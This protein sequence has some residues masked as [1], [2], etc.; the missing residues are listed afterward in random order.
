M[1]LKAPD[2]EAIAK[3]LHIRW[4]LMLLEALPMTIA[5]ALILW[6][7]RIR[8][9]EAVNDGAQLIEDYGDDWPTA[10]QFYEDRVADYAFAS[11]INRQ[12]NNE[13]AALLS[14]SSWC[15]AGGIVY[16]L[17][18]VLFAIGRAQWHN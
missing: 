11:S 12:L 4:G 2:A 6:A 8:N 14:W 5:L 13:T 10:E 15:M 16:L 3:T 1:I 18:I 7:L 17:G 9:F